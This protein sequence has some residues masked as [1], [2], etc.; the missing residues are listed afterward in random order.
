VAIVR[1]TGRVLR[2]AYQ[3]TDVQMLSTLGPKTGRFPSSS[4]PTVA[5]VSYLLWRK[6]TLRQEE[7]PV[8]AIP[9][10]TE[11]WNSGGTKMPLRR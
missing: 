6:L 5:P 8:K 4:V 10:S 3:T 7:V 9:K 1:P 11:F 2:K